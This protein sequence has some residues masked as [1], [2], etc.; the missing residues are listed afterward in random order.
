MC[1]ICETQIANDDEFCLDCTVSISQ[2]LE[3]LAEEDEE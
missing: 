2:A 3:E 1:E